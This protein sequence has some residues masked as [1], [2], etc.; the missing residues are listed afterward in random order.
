MSEEKSPVQMIMEARPEMM[1]NYLTYLDS[2]GKSLDDKT[3]Q[4]IV[5][6]VQ[7]ASR[8]QGGVRAHIPKA[9]KAGATNEEMLDAMLIAMPTIGL[10]AILQ[11]IPLILKED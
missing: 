6:A 4:L 11:I 7:T 3:R 9:R 2:L 8:S 5:L 10:G 1:K